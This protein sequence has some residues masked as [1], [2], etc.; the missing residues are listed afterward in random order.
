MRIIFTIPSFLILFSVFGKLFS[1]DLFEIERVTQDAKSVVLIDYDTKRIFYAKNPNLIFPPASLTKL[2]TIYTALVE[3][4]K[5]NI[6]LKTI[7]PISSAASYYNLPLGSSLMFLEEGHKVN[8]EELLKGL[9][10][11]SGND[12]AIAIAEFIVGKNLI[13]FVNLMNINVLN[14]GLANMNFVDTSGYCNGNQITAL[15]MALFARAYI[16]EFEFMLDIHSLRDFI[17]PRSENLGSTSSSK[18]LNLKQENRNVLIFNYPYADGLKTGYIKTSGLNLVATAKKDDIRL[19]AVVLGVN[20][21]INSVGEKKRAFIAQKLFE[22][23]FSNY[24]RF[25]FHW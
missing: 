1:I 22:Y 9:V 18:M 13:N 24:S 17:Y 5:K 20:K 21:G 6:D 14:L 2:V 10:I 3:A 16:E 25:P 8:F 23:G 11:S 7:V 12:A 4:R 15:E 19:I